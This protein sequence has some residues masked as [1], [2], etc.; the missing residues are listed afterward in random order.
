MGSI[1]FYTGPWDFE[2]AKH[3][4]S[5]AMFA[6]SYEQIIWSVEQGLEATIERLLVSNPLPE[7]P[8]NSFYDG[9]PE[10]SVGSTWI[11]ARYEEQSV[12]EGLNYRQRS[13][14]AWTMKTILEE[15]ISAREKLTLFFHNHFAINSVLDER[16]LY[17]YIS[18]IRKFCLGD[19]R[20]L[21]K[22]IAIDPSM[23]RYLN[24]RQNK[25]G[26]PNENFAR[27][28]LELFTV[29]KG[30]QV[31]P[32]DYSHYTERDIVEIAR[33]MTGWYDVGYTDVEYVGEVGARFSIMDHSEGTKEL[34]IHFNQA[35]IPDL[36]DQEYAYVIDVIFSSLQASR[37]LAEKLF[38]WYIHYD[39]TL[40]GVD[41][42]LD[43]LAETVREE[44][45]NISAILATFWKSEHF[46]EVRYRASMIKNPMDYIMGI[47]KTGDLQISET[48]DE[49][50]DSFY[51]LFDFL[52][53]MQM[54][55]F[56]IPE[57]AGWKAYY[58]SPLYS[59]IWINATTL[60]VRM[61][62]VDDLLVNGLYPFM[63]NGDRI[64]VRFLPRLL[65]I[66]DAS[67][68]NFVLEFL[69]KITLHKPLKK[70]EQETMKAILLDGLPDFEW[71]LQ[72][73]SYLTEPT[74]QLEEV[75][76]LRINRALQY[77]FRHPVFQLH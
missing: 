43:D 39:M 23:L 31:G 51:R 55:Y 77:A 67:D 36:L 8:V 17:R 33:S 47:L 15:G 42:Y 30:P 74:P 25:R 29:G 38:G 5:R 27:E 16:Y 35:Q 54:E 19:Y 7:P 4:L 76:S 2:S 40:E 11:H 60:P 52:G 10:V 18:T 48:L 41:E 56:D 45:F 37:F 28:L 68:P 20:T 26:A 65:L 44:Q 63:T 22:A 64:F 34:S 53:K 62:L 13:L 66:P 14:T 61:Q 9:D 49:R 73:E 69:Q 50:Y 58:R 57:A 70:E 1:R 75:L 32:G 21:T 46:Y 6:P 59:R 12:N 24:G 72:F 71:T 3:L